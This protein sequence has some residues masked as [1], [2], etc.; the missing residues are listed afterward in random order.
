MACNCWS[1]KPKPKLLV[2]GL[3]QSYDGAP[4][5]VTV[6]TEP[7]GLG[8]VVTYSLP[9]AS[10][11]N[12]GTYAYAASLVP[13]PNYEASPVS[14][15]FTVNKAIATLTIVESTLSQVYDGQ[16][17]PVT[18]TVEPANITGVS[19]RYDGSFFP[20]VSAKNYL[21]DVTLSNPTTRQLPSAA[22]SASAKPP[23]R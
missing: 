15:I 16:P 20:P 13:N 3:V 18:V 8:S 5:E 9:A 1:T 4:K 2:G 22:C 14:G 7:A 17:K 21:V 19:V 11:V 6:T 23:L 10:R 12:A